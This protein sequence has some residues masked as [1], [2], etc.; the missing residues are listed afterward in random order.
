M[1]KQLVIEILTGSLILLFVY[2]GLYKIINPGIMEMDL[3]KSE[4]PEFLRVLSTPLAYLVPL[5]ELIIAGLLLFPK[6]RMIGF[7][8][9]LILMTI[10]TLYVSY[11]VFLFHG[12]QR[13]CTCGGIFRKMSWEIHLI[14]N[15]FFTGI[16]F[17]GHRLLKKTE[18]SRRGPTSFQYS[19]SNDLF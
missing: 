9:S 2:T 7:L 13:P 17:L 12:V 14:V 18:M 6:S 1:K 10:F 11:I 5:A 16:S 3:S 8:G 19:I 15:L 4:Q